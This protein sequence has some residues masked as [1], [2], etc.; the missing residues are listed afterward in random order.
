MNFIDDLKR[1]MARHYLIVSDLSD[2]FGIS[3]STAYRLL[4]G[5]KKITR[6]ELDRYL[7]AMAKR[8]PD[9]FSKPKNNDVSIVLTEGDILATCLKRHR[10]SISELQ[11][12]V[13]AQTQANKSTL[14]NIG[15]ELI[16]LH[17]DV[18]SLWSELQAVNACLDRQQAEIEAMSKR[19]LWNKIKSIFRGDK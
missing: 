7:A 14:N 1:F 4:N 12:A 2:L 19:G 16:A 10:D 6:P 13:N 17:E 5:Q 8:D 15:S 18:S 9:F 11:M 3:R